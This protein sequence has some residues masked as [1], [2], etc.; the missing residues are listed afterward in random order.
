[1]SD[2]FL[3]TALYTTPVSALL[4]PVQQDRKIFYTY[5]VDRPT[6]KW[7]YLLY[8]DD[9]IMRYK[10]EIRKTVEKQTETKNDRRAFEHL[11]V[12]VAFDCALFDTTRESEGDRHA[13]DEKK[14]RKDEI[15]RRP[16]MPLRVLER[17]VDAG[18]SA[19]IVYEH[20]ARDR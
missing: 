3:D 12:Q 15:G 6:V 8:N 14:E 2:P 19:G 10:L 18:P 17:P 4:V 5:V 1:M 11:E 16:A 13:D 7:L 9:I 20:H